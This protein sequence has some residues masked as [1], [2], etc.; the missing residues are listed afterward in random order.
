MLIVWAIYKL[1]YNTLGYNKQGYK[2]QK[3]IF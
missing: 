2:K 3:Y 1:G